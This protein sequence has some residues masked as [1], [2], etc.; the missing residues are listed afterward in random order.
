M[1]VLPPSVP[2]RSAEF[3]VNALAED[4]RGSLWIGTPEGLLRYRS[5]A[6]SWFGEGCN[7]KTVR[8][9][10]VS[11]E[12]ELWAG[13]SGGVSRLDLRRE[14]P[15]VTNYCFGPGQRGNVQSI[16]EFQDG[17]I[18]MGAFGLARFRPRPG[19]SR[20]FKFFDNKSMV[21]FQYI[22]DMAEDIA[23]NRWLA[24]QQS[25]V[26]RILRPGFSQFAESDGLD[27]SSSPF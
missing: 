19:L 18:W 6:A 10:H 16:H 13:Y 14:P 3:T 25:G 12:G 15:G 11:R 23:G 21:G 1:P 5:G 8:S 26:M 7:T 24:L 20:P 4:G 2:G 27:P 9:L 17:E 22:Y